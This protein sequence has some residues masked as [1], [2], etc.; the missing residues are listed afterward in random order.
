[1]WRVISY[2][3][4]SSSD[5]ECRYSQTKKEAL[6]LVWACERFS[7][8]VTGE[9][10]ELET[11]HKPLERIYSRTSKPCARI[12][13]WV[14][15]LQGFNFIVVYQPGKTNIADALSRLNSVE[16]CDGGEKY[17]FVKT[18]VGNSVPVALSP[19]EI[20]EASYN[21][22]ELCQVKNCV[23]S[24]NWERCT[25]SSYVP[26][27][28]ELCIYGEILL[29][30]TRIVVPRILRDKVV[31]LAHEGHQGMVKTKYRLR[32]KVWWPGMDKDAEKVCKVCHGCQVT[33]GYDPP[34]PMSRVLPPT[35]PWQDCSA[36]L[37]GPL[38]SGE[39][40]LVVVDYFSRFLEVAILKSTTSAKIIEAIS[41]MFARF[42]VPFSLRT[43]NGPQ[44]VSEEFETFLR[45]HGVE[46][47]RTTP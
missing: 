27:K 39:S 19:R 35:A 25:L 17:D 9:T 47:R 41:P 22:E 7:V 8:Y 21:D 45:S 32:N 11:D 20:E 42:G 26:I 18:I 24:G 33:S 43:D 23:R 34:E 30:G 38:P 1:M 3:S 14:L 46:H 5:V 31:R 16:S 37:L 36:D 2:A 12:E 40:I 29:R 28:D 44:F 13:R 4:R 10:F 15:R 6:A